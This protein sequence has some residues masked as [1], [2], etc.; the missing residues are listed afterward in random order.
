M[1]KKKPS[2]DPIVNLIRSF[3]TRK[4]AKRPYVVPL[5]YLEALADNLHRQNPTKVI[6]FNTLKEL[7]CK[8]FEDCYA[9]FT[10][11]RL[12]WRANREKALKADF[13]KVKDEIDDM[14]HAK[15]TNQ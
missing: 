4:R 14:V 7:Y 5:A 2:K 13:D 1:G 8:V 9:R 15:A 3:W 10:D 11:D 6:V 12:W